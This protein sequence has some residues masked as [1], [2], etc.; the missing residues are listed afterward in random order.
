MTIYPEG[1]VTVADAGSTNGLF[2]DGRRI[3]GPTPA[4]PTSVI[5]V[6]RTDLKVIDI[7]RSLVNES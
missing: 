5:R 2:L 7:L 3:Y 6:G 4:G 1:V